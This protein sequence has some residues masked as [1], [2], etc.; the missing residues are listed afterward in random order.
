MFNF[1]FQWILDGLFF[2]WQQN[3][4]NKKILA[5][6]K[7]ALLWGEAQLCL[8]EKYSDLKW[9]WGDPAKVVLRGPTVALSIMRLQVGW[10]G[11]LEVGNQ[12]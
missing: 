4:P 2:R 12:I 7:L 3:M 5:S 11:W 9:L 1:P 10:V 6:D 8:P